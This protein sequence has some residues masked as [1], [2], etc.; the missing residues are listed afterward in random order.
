VFHQTNKNKTIIDMSKTIILFLI[1]MFTLPAMSQPDGFNYDE[2]KVPKFDLPELLVLPNGR[3]VKSVKVWENK[4]RPETLRIFEEQV[5]GKIPADLKMT[6]FRVM[7]ESDQTPYENAVRKQ[8][9]ML[10]E[11][12]GKELRVE[13]LIYL[14]KTT[15]K[16]PVFLGYN[17]YGNHTITEDVNV[18]ISRS[19]VRDNPS[20]GIVHNQLTEQSRGVRNNRWSVAEILKSGYGLATIY[21]GDVDPDR[22]DFSDGVHPFLYQD[23]QTRPLANEW[24][25]I[26]A[27]AWGLSRAMDYFETDPAIDASKV[28]VMGHSRL[29]KASLW[30][31]ASDQRF[32]MVISNNSGCGGAALSRR[33]FGE[34]VKRINTN[35][36]HWFNTNFK[37]YNDN[38]NNLPIDQHQL[39]ALVAPRPVYIA[40]AAEDLWAD[41]R[42]EYLAGYYASPVYKLYGKAGLTTMEM[43]GIHEPVMNHVGYHIRA[44]KHD[45]T[46]YDWKQYIRFADKHFFN[47]NQ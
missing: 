13:I 26:S 24:G 45:V 15:E 33:K 40:S 41:P 39:I 11:K 8:V 16:V 27:W 44:G 28:A 18:I 17:F 19:W 20:F 30:A 7:E 42:G 34:T 4:K 47:K 12:D 22:D 46:D 38:E 2:S 3:K 31:G 29:G 5:Y 9:E 36:P 14:P 35:F 43:P 23:G 6:S 37:A 32:A 1:I 21:Y 10:L 25:A